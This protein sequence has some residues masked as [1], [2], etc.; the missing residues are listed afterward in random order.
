VH[1]TQPWR[2]RLTPNGLDVVL[3]LTRRLCVIDSEGREALISCGAA[4]FNARTA[5]A[6][7]GFALRIRRFPR[8][9]S[10]PLC[11]RLEILDVDHPVW[12]A[13]LA[14]LAAAIRIRS[15]NRRAFDGRRPSPESIARWRAAAA[16]EDSILVELDR[17]DQRRTVAAISRRA[18]AL[19]TADPHYRAELRAWTGVPAG[20]SD[21][22][23]ACVIP[24][25]ETR[26]AEGLALRDFDAHDTGTLPAHVGAA[27]DP[28][29]LVLGSKVDDPLAWLRTGEAL[30]R[31]LLDMANYGWSTSPLSQ[32]LELPS[33]RLA[34][35]RD[36]GL[37]FY[38]Q[39]L[40]RVGRAVTQPAVT[41]R[42]PL[43]EVLTGAE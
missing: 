31:I 11:A 34:L 35:A 14:G 26:A 40:I 30:E 19:E 12:D 15:T 20:R 4:L 1:N 16:Q 29:L 10:H 21:G 7:E 17:P 25:T 2:F 5:L 13:D 6:G 37:P 36:L 23:P 27:G 24:P 28:T 22:V 18:D 39:L 43:S 3:D 33:T 9:R 41:P 42:R 8:G 32:A 38:P